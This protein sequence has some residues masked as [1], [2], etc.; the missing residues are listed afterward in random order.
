MTGL[1]QEKGQFGP[2]VFPIFILITIL[3]TGISYSTFMSFYYFKSVSE[4]QYVTQ[5]YGPFHE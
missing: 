4:L 3:Y 5:Q 1:C 2:R